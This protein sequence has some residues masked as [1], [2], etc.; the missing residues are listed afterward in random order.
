MDSNALVK[1]IVFA[2][3]IPPESNLQIVDGLPVGHWINE[4]AFVYRVQPSGGYYK[5]IPVVSNEFSFLIQPGPKL[6][7]NEQAAVL[8]GELADLLRAAQ[9]KQT[10]CEFQAYGRKFSIRHTARNSFYTSS[11]GWSSN[12]DDAAYFDCAIEVIRALEDIQHYQLIDRSLL[13]VGMTSIPDNVV[14]PVNVDGKPFVVLRALRS[15]D[16]CITRCSPN[17]NVAL[18]ANGRLAYDVVAFCDS[19]D[20][21]QP[22]WEK[23]LYQ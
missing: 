22:I 1:S 5:G 20:E 10:L 23:A 16:V 8:G 19:Y 3:G 11:G 18:L 12:P 13:E 7:T 21:A 9:F 15:E 4:G 6:A 17:Q 2:Y 14:N